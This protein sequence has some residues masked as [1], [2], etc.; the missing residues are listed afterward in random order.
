[1]DEIFL[2]SLIGIKNTVEASIK[3]RDDG[4]YDFSIKKWLKDGDDIVLGTIKGIVNI[5]NND[6]RLVCDPDREDGTIM[7]Q[8]EIDKSIRIGIEGGQQ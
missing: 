2:N 7:F 3:K 6:I 5:S 8:L 1:M 4:L